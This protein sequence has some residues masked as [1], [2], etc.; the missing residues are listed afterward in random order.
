MEENSRIIAQTFEAAPTGATIVFFSTPATDFM[1]GQV[2]SV[3]GGLTM[4]G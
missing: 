1:T 4:H 3:S 2:V